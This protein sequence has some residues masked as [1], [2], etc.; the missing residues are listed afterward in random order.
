VGGAGRD[1]SRHRRG[2]RVTIFLDTI[3]ACGDNR[4]VMVRCVEISSVTVRPEWVVLSGVTGVEAL[5]NR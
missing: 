2:L 3:A 1:A 5:R 4:G